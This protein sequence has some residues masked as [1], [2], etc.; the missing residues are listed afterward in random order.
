MGGGGFSDAGEVTALESYAL[1]L[2]G[3]EK[4]QVCFVATASGDAEGYIWKFYDSFQHS[5]CETTHLDLFNRGED[6][7][8]E[9]TI[10]SSD[11]I[12]V[13]GGNT[14]NLLAIWNLH[15]VTPLL[16]QAYQRGTV[17][18][19]VS[20][21]GLCWFQSGLSDSFGPSLRFVTNGI[22]L[23]PGAFCPHLDTEESRRGRYLEELL[24]HRLDG[25][26]AEDD[27]AIHFADEALHQVIAFPGK[28]AYRFR[29]EGDAIHEEILAGL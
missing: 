22:G 29:I 19:G 28:N 25:Y 16:K 2:T 20:A 11:V 5:G 21:G 4:P 26:G 1:D 24:K 27:A 3:K 9:E 6:A 7:Q 12:L 23:L 18:A 8:I 14:A 15:G 10:L 17:M 13:G